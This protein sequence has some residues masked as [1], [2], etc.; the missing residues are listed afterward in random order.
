M[1][2]SINLCVYYLGLHNLKH[3]K[4]ISFDE[5]LAVLTLLSHKDVGDLFTEVV[6]NKTLPLPFPKN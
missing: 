1:I 2:L 5:I 3:T 4:T 6:K